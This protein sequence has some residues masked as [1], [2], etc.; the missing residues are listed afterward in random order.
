VARINW[1]LLTGTFE[2]SMEDGELRFRNAFP[3]LDSLPTD[4]QLRFMVF[5][6]WNTTARY[7]ASLAE[8]ALGDIDPVAAI[9]KA[10]DR[11][12][13]SLVEAIGFGSESVN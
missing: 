10:K 7:A 1:Q 13:Q 8:V 2:I 4:Q 12:P 6:S 3:M 5:E 9:S 11:L